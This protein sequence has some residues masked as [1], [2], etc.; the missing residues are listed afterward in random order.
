MQIPIFRVL[1][2]SN[3]YKEGENRKQQ[4]DRSF[5]VQTNKNLLKVQPL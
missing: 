4:K 1:K 3:I 5:Y 2:M